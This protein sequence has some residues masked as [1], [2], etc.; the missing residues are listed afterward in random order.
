[1]TTWMNFEN[2]MLTEKYSQNTTYFI[3]LLNDSCSGREFYYFLLTKHATM[4]LS[5]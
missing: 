1:M 4:V 5:E 2:I 3:F